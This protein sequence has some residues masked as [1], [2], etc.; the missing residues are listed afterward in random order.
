MRKTGY[1]LRALAAASALFLASG[2]ALAGDEEQALKAIAQ[3]QGK[4]DA[5][6]KLQAGQFD[7][8]VLA[9]AQASLRLAQERLKSGKEQD[10]IKAAVEAQ[11]FAD[12]A[13]GQTQ[14]SIRT[15]AQVQASTAAPSTVIEKTTTTVTKR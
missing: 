9:Q 8:A 5:A 6:A 15:D 2:P 10:A 3:A 1:S 12:T 13:I 4:I 7:P 14:A 11:G